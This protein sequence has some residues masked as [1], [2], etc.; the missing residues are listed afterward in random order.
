MLAAKDNEI[1]AKVKKLRVKALTADIEVL[2]EEDPDM[3]A[4][5]AQQDL[6][7]KDE[8]KGMDNMTNTSKEY[9]VRDSGKLLFKLD[10]ILP[11]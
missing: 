4:A 8:A 3:G 5:N 9:K 6:S 2:N 11:G 1:N 7:V 10:L